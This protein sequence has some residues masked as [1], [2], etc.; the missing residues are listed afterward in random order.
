MKTRTATITTITSTSFGPSSISV[1]IEILNPAVVRHIN[2]QRIIGDSFFIE[3]IK[4]LAARFIKPVAH[5]KVRRL[6]GWS[7]FALILLKQAVRRIVWS[8]GQERCVPDKERILVSR[9]GINEICDR[10]QTLLSG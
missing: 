9:R 10:M 6:V 7:V 8:M 5:G 2:H 4:Q 1:F 3:S